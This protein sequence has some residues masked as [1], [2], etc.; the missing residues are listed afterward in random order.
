MSDDVVK[1]L[2]VRWLSFGGLWSVVVSH[3]SRLD[4]DADD[5]G[6]ES[7]AGVRFGPARGYSETGIDRPAFAQLSNSPKQA[8]TGQLGEDH[9]LQ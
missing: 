4:Q 8:P 6:V 9:C 5:G 3:R 1:V 2:E 7:G